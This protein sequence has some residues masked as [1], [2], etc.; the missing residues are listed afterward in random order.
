M[1]RYVIKRILLLIPILI[2][3]SFIVFFIV[4]LAPGDSVD[5][6]FGNEMSVSEKEVMREEL[7]YNDPLVVRYIRYMGNLLRGDMGMSVSFKKP[8]MELYFNRLPA[9]LELAFW[10]IL[11]ALLIAIPLGIVSA[12]HQNTLIDTSS[13]V[14]GLLGMSMPSFWF[15]LLLVILFSLKL[16]WL[17][18]FGSEG[19]GAIIMPALT[20]GVGQAALL[21]R[22]TRSSMLEVIRQD[23]LR[24]ARAKGVSERSVIYRHALRNALIPIITATGTQL[25]IALGGSVV[26]ESVFAWPG[27]G[28]LTIDAFYARDTTLVVGCLIL[29]TALSSVLMMLVD[30]IYAYIDPRIKARYMN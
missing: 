3:V 23:F 5:A 21:I 13:T 29:T 28:K 30:I 10:G 19:I 2:A 6:V 26:I 9:T 16:G 1:Y 25:G 24:T 18:S 20:L 8:A 11:V 7:G 4:D 15:G 14:L 27:V 12:V 17:P 22:T